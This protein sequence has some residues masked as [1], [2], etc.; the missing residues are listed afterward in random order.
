VRLGELRL[1]GVALLAGLGG[2]RLGLL[3]HPLLGAEV[4]RDQP[5]PVLERLALEP[6]VRLGGLRLRLQRP[7]VAARLALD[8]EHARE[9]VARWLE[10]ELRA[11]AALAVLAE[12]GGL[13]DEQP[14]LARLRMHDL[15]DLALADH[16]VHLA[17]E[18]RV[19][20]HLE[21]VGEP[22]AGA[23]EQVLAFAGALEAVLAW[24]LRQ[25]G[26]AGP[27]GV[28]ATRLEL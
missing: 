13:L 19:G 8:V 9:G 21:H 4:A 18:V 2:A 15:L 23:V 24:S 11:A 7:Q 14:A 1:D 28:V 27:V 25:L 22:A 3:K 5:R 17:A 16:R 6:R 20:E 10:L 12:P 26:L